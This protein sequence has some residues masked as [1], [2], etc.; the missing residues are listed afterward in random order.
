MATCSS[1]TATEVVGALRVRGA[2]AG[3]VAAITAIYADA[4]L[5]GTSSYEIEPPGVD[6]MSSRMQ[7]GVAAGHPWLVAVAADG[8]VAGYAYASAYRTRPG[9]AWTVEDSVYVAPA[10]R[11]RGAGRLLLEALIERCTALGFRQ[12]VAV[13][14]DEANR[15]SIAL[16]E[17]AGFVVAA[18]FP[19]LGRKQGRWLTNV[20]MQRALGDGAQTAPFA[21]PGT[22]A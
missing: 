13:I 17:R 9:Y 5:H 22:P 2:Q 8:V 20:Q 12:M 18:R 6:A 19:A 16:H 21:E 1:A 15:A 11:G 4:V 3:D 7:A 10:F 14:G